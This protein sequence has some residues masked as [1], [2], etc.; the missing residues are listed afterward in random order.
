VINRYVFHREKKGT[1]FLPE[2][3][4]QAVS[5]DRIAGY[6]DSSLLEFAGEAFE[7][8]T[9]LIRIICNSDLNAEDILTARQVNEKKSEQA[10]KLSFFKHDAQTLAVEGKERLKRLYTLLKRSDLQI[11][12]LP[13]DAFGLVHGKAGVISYEDGTRTSFLPPVST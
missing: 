7:Q 5:Y 10:Q 9:G 1:R 6:F 8:V 13:N 12:V 4:K 3:L 11:R 2:R